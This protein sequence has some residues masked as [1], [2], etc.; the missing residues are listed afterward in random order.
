MI[1]GWFPSEHNPSKLLKHKWDGEKWVCLSFATFVP[2]EQ[3]SQDWGKCLEQI[4]SKD[5]IRWPSI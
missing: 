4:N 2:I 5:E 3:F 1:I